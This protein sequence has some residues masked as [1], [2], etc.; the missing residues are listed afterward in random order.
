MALYFD[1]QHATAWDPGVPWR[2]LAPTQW[3]EWFQPGV[4]LGQQRAGVAKQREYVLQVGALLRI[5]VFD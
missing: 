2:D 5:F 1:T 3:E 4:T